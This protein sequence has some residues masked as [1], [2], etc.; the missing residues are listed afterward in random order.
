MPFQ[1]DRYAQPEFYYAKRRTRQHNVQPYA[2]TRNGK[3]F[4]VLFFHGALS[5][6]VISMACWQLLNS[7]S[8]PF[9]WVLFVMDTTPDS[10]STSESY[11]NLIRSSSDSGMEIISYFCRIECS[12]L[13]LIWFFVDIF[14]FARNF[15][16]LTNQQC[17]RQPFK[18]K[19]IKEI[20][21]YEQNWKLWAAPFF[22]LLFR[23]L[24]LFLLS[25]FESKPQNNNTTIAMRRKER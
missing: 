8:V 16:T 4:F 15:L 5:V 18:R 9:S 22:W 20:I 24:F 14:Y 2:Y 17:R 12:P 11:Y 7:L 19:K 21:K 13:S 25:W 1:N 10:L 6:R 3:S 23:V